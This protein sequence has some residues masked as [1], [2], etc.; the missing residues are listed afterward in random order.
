VT[1]AGS[2]LMAS[3]DTT[4]VVGGADLPSPEHAEMPTR[5]TMANPIARVSA[6][7]LFA[8]EFRDTTTFRSSLHT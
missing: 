8:D 5:P 6:T 2:T 3:G 4:A 7:R 1:T